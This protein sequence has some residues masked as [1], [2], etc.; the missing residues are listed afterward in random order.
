MAWQGGIP[1]GGVYE[2]ENRFRVRFCTKEFSHSKS[3]CYTKYEDKEAA[4]RQAEQ[5][6]LSISNEKGLLK[7]RWR[8]INNGEAIEMQLTKNKTTVFDT[9]DEKGEKNLD[10]LIQYV[11]SASTN[12]H[13]GL[14]YAHAKKKEGA[15][16][17]RT[18][19]MHRIICPDFRKVDHINGDTLDNRKSNLRDGSN[20]VNENN[21]R[22]L[23]NN[24]SGH[25]GIYFY[26]NYAVLK[27]REDGK[28]KTKMFPFSSEE[29][30]DIALQKVIEYRDT[31]VYPVIG[32][33]NGKRPKM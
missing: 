8:Y 28:S 29:T 33:T 22:M 25:N 9:V 1:L 26:K 17:Y 15:V 14:W 12:N 32:N 18:V 31:V 11:W 27:W 5:Y 16:K 24:T 7:N 4:R 13:P 6:M 19:K 21:K 2:E 23:K 20:G 10:K 30:K 3:F